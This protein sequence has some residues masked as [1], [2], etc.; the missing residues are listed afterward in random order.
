MAYRSGVNKARSK[1]WLP[2]DEGF[3]KREY[4]EFNN[5]KSKSYEAFLKQVGYALEKTPQQIRNKL[6][7]MN[8]RGL[9][10]K[11]EH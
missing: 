4:T 2:G 11:R 3:L 10:S 8:R 7:D 9:I 1:P 6:K 5:D